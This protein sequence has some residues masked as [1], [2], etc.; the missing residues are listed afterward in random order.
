MKFPLTLQRGRS[1]CGPTCLKMVADYYGQDYA[2]NF[3]KRKCRVTEAG[4]SM[5]N[6][7]KAAEA[8]GFES[9][10]VKIN[11][12]Q[13]KKI[14]QDIPVIFHFNENHFVVIYK[15]P[16]PKK[17]GVFCLADP[18]RGLV[19]YKEA[20]FIKYWIGYEKN[21]ENGSLSNEHFNNSVGC[22][23]LLEP[24]PSFYNQPGKTIK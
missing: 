3:L 19:T 13:L 16:K 8:I 10:G 11:I 1:D 20:E 7:S 23:L 5:L 6:I 12:E 2:L 14:V 22:C 4:A 9:T 24:T 17:T 15:A 18:S 21:K